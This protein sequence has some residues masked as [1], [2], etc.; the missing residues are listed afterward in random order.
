MWTSPLLPTLLLSSVLCIYRLAFRERS[1]SVYGHNRWSALRSVSRSVQFSRLVIS[2]C[3]WPHGQQHTRLPC[4]SP[5]P[6]AKEWQWP[7]TYRKYSQ[8]CKCSVNHD[9]PSS[10]YNNLIIS[11]CVK[12]REGFIFKFTNTLNPS[13]ALLLLSLQCLILYF[14]LQKFFIPYR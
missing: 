2:N 3:L 9:F 13:M 8:L 14:H 1:R 10:M 11:V 7:E 5:T 4:P 12:E 6:R